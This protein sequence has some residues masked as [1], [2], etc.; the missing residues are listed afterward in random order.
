VASPVGRTMG[1]DRVEPEPTRVS[2][3][4]NHASPPYLWWNDRIAAHFFRP[5]MAGRRVYLYVTDDLIAHAGTGEGAA[6]KEFVAAVK[7]GPK[8]VQPQGLCQMALHAMKAWRGRNLEYP[9]YV[10]YLG[11]FV[12]AAGISGDF[13]GHAYY[14]RLKALLGDTSHSGPLPSFYRM[15][16]LWDD[17]EEWSTRDKEGALGIFISD[18]VGGWIHVG[19]PIGQ[20]VLTEDERA[21]LPQVFFTAGLDPTAIPP[22]E[23]LASVLHRYGHEHLKPRTLRLLHARDGEQEQRGVLIDTIVEALRSWNGAVEEAVED[24]TADG[25][26]G[27]LRL[28]IQIDSVAETARTTLRCRS[29]HQYPEGGLVLTSN[30]SEQRLLADEF[31]NGWSEPVREATGEIVDGSRLDWSR[32]LSMR[33]PESGWVLRLSASSVRVFVDG[34]SEGLPWL[35]DAN[36]LPAGSAFFVAAS[37]GA[38]ERI[39]DWGRHDCTGFA[40]VNFNRGLPPGWRFYR[41]D[42]ATNDDLVR[43]EFPVLRL[44]AGVRLRLEG[45]IPASPGQYFAFAPPELLIEGASNGVKIYCNERRIEAPAPGGR[46]QV[47]TWARSGGRLVVEAREGGEVRSRRSIYL[48]EDYPWVTGFPVEWFDRSGHPANNGG[49][50]TP[51]VAGALVKGVE[52]PPLRPSVL[53]GLEGER[54]VYLV[55]RVAGQIVEWPAESLP[56][57]WSPTWAIPLRRRSRAVFCGTGLEGAEP[58]RRDVPDGRKVRDWKDLLYYRRKRIDPPTNLKLR[59]LWRRYQEYAGDLHR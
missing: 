40:P 26:L 27:A 18:S 3:A 53:M 48:V 34:R 43:D 42:A 24:G 37:A 14:P 35:V 46:Y 23:Q 36:Q 4:G 13:A 6:R 57:S 38:R 33:D 2:L 49:A 31:M 19:L 20:T 50:G 9:P 52:T 10:G 8:W 11:L 30:I 54:Q 29:N 7:E 12:L 59:S 21:A 15:Q 44:P 1:P 25:I 56:R 41:A 28:C 17:L 39:E 55:G 47:P 16:E 58:E 32:G 5:E 45:G 51:V 22:D